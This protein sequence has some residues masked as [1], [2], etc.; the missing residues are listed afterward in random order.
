VT[1]CSSWRGNDCQVVCAEEWLE[2]FEEDKHHSHLIFSVQFFHRCVLDLF[3]VDIVFLVIAVNSLDRIHL[4]FEDVW[5][6]AE[7]VF[8]ELG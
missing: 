2:L 8:E 5:L 7:K 3:D 4:V 1:T 6:L